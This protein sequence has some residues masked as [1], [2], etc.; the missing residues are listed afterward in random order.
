MMGEKSLPE[1]EKTKERRKIMQ[2]KKK[3]VFGFLFSLALMLGLVL[4]MNVTAWATSGNP[5]PNPINLGD[6]SQNMKDN[7]EPC[8]WEYSKDTHTLTLNGCTISAEG[9]G[10]YYDGADAL[11]IELKEG[12]TNSIKSTKSIGIKS[13]STFLIIQG[14]GSLEVVSEAN[15]GYNGIDA[16]GDIVIK[17]D[18]KVKA[19]GTRDSIFAGGNVTVS[20]NAEVTA[21][22]TSSGINLGSRTF[23][24]EGKAKVTATGNYGISAKTVNIGEDVQLT[25]TGSSGGALYNGSSGAKI[26]TKV[27]GKAWAKADG[28][29]DEEVIKT[30]GTS[31]LPKFKK[32]VFPL[33]IKVTYTVGDTGVTGE[34]YVIEDASYKFTVLSDLPEGWT[35]PKGYQFSHWRM[36]HGSWLVDAMPGDKEEITEDVTFTPIILEP[37]PATVTTA[38]EAKTLTYNGSAQELVTEGKASNGTMQYAAGTDA[39][40]APAESAYS[41]AIPSGI[42]AGTYYVWYKVKGDESHTDSKAAC[43]TATINKKEVSR[44][45]TFKVVNGSWDDGTSKDKTETLKGYEG[46]ELKLS[47][48][49]IPAVGKK[50][51]SGYAAGSWDKTPSTKTAITKDITYTY[52]YAKASAKAAKVSKAPTAKKLTYNGKDQNLVNAGKASNGKMYYAVTKNTTAP[53][54]SAYKT[55]IPTGKTAGTYYVWYKVKGDKGYKD[56]AVKKVKVTIAKA[57]EEPFNFNTS[58]KVTQKDGQ[59]TVTWNK[60]N[61]LSKVDAYVAYCGTNYPEKKIATTTKNTLTIKKIAGKKIDLTKDFKLTLVGYG[62]D[63]KTKKSVSLHIAGK[64][65]KKFTNV[66]SFTLSKASVSVKKGKSTKVLVETYKLEDTGKKE[67][68]DGHAAKFRY[69]STNSKIA[70]VDK[71]GRITGVKE[72]KCKVFVYTRN[73]LARKIAVTVTK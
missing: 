39:T 3:R 34:D 41:E 52:T 36:K 49:Q 37:S 11:T 42:E 16:N 69:R 65:N 19:A 71:N 12:S 29:G 72:G 35:L 40:T 9:N 44:T 48:D 59:V 33:T 47:K 63:K 64:D 25:A 1:T 30:G 14:S 20:D 22:G 57:V 67:L 7:S 58:F 31:L 46:D 23:T 45:V 6:G 61:G 38:P 55:S 53:K 60:V 32:A 13:K 27:V 17:G 68:S 2:M 10:I 50:P 24:A 73:G 43:V 26:N 62:T 28:T 4:G 5:D 56:S 66:K 51:G 54:A 70:K 8:T 18:A 15:T 21:E